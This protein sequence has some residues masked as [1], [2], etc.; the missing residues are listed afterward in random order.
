M[1]L[2]EILTLEPSPTS[3][4]TDSVWGKNEVR[5]FEQGCLYYLALSHSASV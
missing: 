2:G 1:H 3:L 4:D 5:K